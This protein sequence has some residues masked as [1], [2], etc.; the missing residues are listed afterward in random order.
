[1]TVLRSMAV[2]L[3]CVCVVALY[4]ALNWK[5]TQNRLKARFAQGAF[6]LRRLASLA[7]FRAPVR[8]VAEPCPS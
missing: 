6:E 5:D 8:R 4:V 7:R 3:V 1:M 2:G